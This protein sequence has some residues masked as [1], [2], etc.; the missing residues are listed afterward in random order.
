MDAKFMIFTCIGIIALVNQ[1]VTAQQTSGSTKKFKL[2]VPFEKVTDCAN[3]ERGDSEVKC[4]KVVDSTDC[5]LKLIRGEVDFGKYSAEQAIV[6]SYFFLT[7]GPNKAVT[8]GETRNEERLHDEF[9]FTAVAI[10]RSKSIPSGNLAKEKGLKLCH[11]GVGNKR[12]G[13]SDRVLN[14]LDL[15]A[16]DSTES[17]QNRRCDEWRSELENQYVSFAKFW[18]PSCRPGLWSPDNEVDKTLKDQ[19]PSLCERCPNKKTCS[20][21]SIQESDPHK[22]ALDCLQQGGDVAYVDQF[23]AGDFINAINGENSEYKLVCQDLNL[24]TNV[25]KCHWSRQPWSNIVARGAI[26]TALSP[27]LADWLKPLGPLKGNTNETAAPRE[28]PVWKK[29]LNNILIED[30]EAYVAI[31]E[32]LVKDHILRGRKLPSLL[33]EPVCKIKTRWCQLEKAEREKC[34]WLAT[35][36]LTAGIVPPIDCL[37]AETGQACSVLVGEHKAD[38]TV[39]NIDDA[40]A[41]SM[42][43]PSNSPVDIR[44]EVNKYIETP[45]ENNH[46]IVALVPAGSRIR[47]IT[48]LRGKKACFPVIGGV[49]RTNFSVWNR[50]AANTKNMFYNDTGALN[51]LHTGGG[52]VAFLNFGAA[53]TVIEEQLIPGIEAK[54]F[55]VLCGHDQFM[56]SELPGIEGGEECALAITPPAAAL[57]RASLESH[58]KN[59]IHNILFSVDYLFGQIEDTHPD[60]SFHMYRQFNGTPGL[61]FPVGTVGMV[62]FDSKLMAAEGYMSLQIGVPKPCGSGDYSTASSISISLALLTIISLFSL[63]R[64]TF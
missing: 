35:A 25:T 23:Y 54:N 29:A 46:H 53:K 11:P 5:A 43:T 14:E 18:G 52:E 27:K 20:Y 31:K 37:G 33:T 58:D 63:M 38:L 12:S 41:S 36:A 26:S 19:N 3:V 22:A 48:E 57:C 42:W 13:W 21:S 55:R 7:D 28:Q 60:P 2:C 45:S 61:I 62:N 39:V 24:G 56:P 16:L 8:I 4:V 47:N 15:A 34:K 1:L 30:D 49:V 10:A 9:A 17:E 51:C 40:H 64:I 59:D 44:V 6:A 32:M 50:C